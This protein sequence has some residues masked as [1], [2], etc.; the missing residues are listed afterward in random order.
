[1][2]AKLNTVKLPRALVA[3]LMAFAILLGSVATGLAVL[4]TD[5]ADTYT[6]CASNT[7]T[8][9]MIK[10]NPGCYYWYYEKGNTYC[11]LTAVESGSAHYVTLT[12]P[13]KSET[14]YLKLSSN[15]DSGSKYDW[16]S[17][18]HTGV[19][20]YKGNTSYTY[21]AKLTYNANG[22]SGAPSAQTGNNSST[23]TSAN[24]TFT[25]PNTTPTRSGYTFLGWAESGSAAT[26]S[27]YAG[28]TYTFSASSTSSSSPTSKTLY[29]VWQDASAPT[30]TNPATATGNDLSLSKTLSYDKNSDTYTITLKGNA[31]AGASTG[32]TYTMD[33]YEKSYS[34]S[35]LKT[36][37]YYYLYDG[38]YYQVLGLEYY[39]SNKG[40]TYYCGYFI[41]NGTTYY[42]DKTPQA[43]SSSQLD[44]EHPGNSSSSKAYESGKSSKVSEGKELPLYTRSGSGSSGTTHGTACVLKDTIN[45]TY[46][47]VSSATVTASPSSATKTIDRSSGL[48]TATNYNYTG[49]YNGTPLTVT[50]S[51]IK[52][53][54]NAYGKT[55]ASNS[56]N[57]GIYASSS[58]S[59]ALVS[60][61]SPTVTLP[62]KQQED[63]YELSVNDVYIDLKDNTRNGLVFLV[64]DTYAYPD[65][66]FTINGV[67]ASSGSKPSTDNYPYTLTIKDTSVLNQAGNMINASTANVG[68]T[69]ATLTIKDLDGNVL[70]TQDFNITVVDTSAYTVNWKNGNSTLETD[71]DV[72]KNSKPSYDGSKPTKAATAQYTYTFSGWS[73]DPNA[74]TGSAVSDL[75][76]VTED[77]TYYAVFNQTLRSYN[78]TFKNGNAQ[79]QSGTINY[80][81]KPIYNGNTP[82]KAD[83][84]NYTYTF[85]GWT[86]NADGSGTI[87]TANT[88]PTVT[89]ATTYYA[90]FKATE[91]PKNYELKVQD[92]TFDLAN[93]TFTG[94]PAAGYGEDEMGVPDEGYVYIY[95]TL[96]GVDYDSDSDH[97]YRFVFE[98]ED[99]SIVN[100]EPTGGAG[101]S[102]FWF[103]IYGTPG[104]TIVTAKLYDVTNVTNVEPLATTTFTVTVYP[105]NITFKNGDET[106]E[107]TTASL[108]QSPQYTKAEPTKDGYTFV[109]WSTNPNATATTGA[110]YP[111]GT[112]LPGATDNTT[113]Y[114]VF[115]KNST[116]TI[117]WVNDDGTVLETD[118][119]VQAGATPSYDGATPSKASTAQYEYIFAGWTPEITKVNGDKTY[120]AVYVETPREYTVRFQYHDDTHVGDSWIT[121]TKEYA[122]GTTPTAPSVKETIVDGNTTYTFTGWDR[123]VSPVTGNI[124]YVAQ[125]KVE[126]FIP[127][128]DASTD[129]KLLPTVTLLA[130][131]AT[132][133]TS[134]V[135]AADPKRRRR[136]EE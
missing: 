82:T 94:S 126:T 119:N 87:Y 28:S 121:N 88:L 107:E 43:Y 110:Y 114:A 10:D 45:I 46:F 21:Y 101:T 33:G 53:K 26:P 123:E 115:E 51:G 103:T 109:G 69:T 75:P 41:A 32:Y 54:D 52:A 105:F 128:T 44:T 13:D 35:N 90:H 60:V 70:A 125:Y 80:G 49:N 34:Y 135:L 72:K 23:S 66:S 7:V 99:T 58:A 50:I 100:F 95:Y 130:V 116:Y 8:W 39:S 73:T 86:T 85:D 76:A 29:A 113:Y 25:I 15:D 108:K 14:R 65:W 19:L 17:K 40:K 56:G 131:L 112:V 20:Y 37:N 55:V 102:D 11:V 27:Y 124:T 64:G 127:E 77:V 92:V 91:K 4:E 132:I 2:T 98:A 96:N 38:N 74:T 3:L 89:G 136:D 42:L 81:T 12:R 134:A 122:Y 104:S 6:T 117:T 106:L 48:V 97:E 9:Q 5:A 133:A 18:A 78:V 16:G 62:E 61:T 67:E 83:D 63:T 36:G 31:T 22:G 68:Q 79:L 118:E 111:K 93:N 47:D 30:I 57:A 129:K 59:S 71:S 84:D 24:V 120:T 1:M